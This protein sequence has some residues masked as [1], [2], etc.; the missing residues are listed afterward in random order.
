VVVDTHGEFAKRRIATTG[1]IAVTKE[2]FKHMLIYDQ[3]SAVD[4][5]TKIHL[6]SLKY[7]THGQINWLIFYV[8]DNNSNRCTHFY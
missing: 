7:Y 8:F 1:D 6:D 4:H 5:E 3:V 2:F